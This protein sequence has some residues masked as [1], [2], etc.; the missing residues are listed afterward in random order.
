MSIYHFEHDF[1]RA[2]DHIRRNLDAGPDFEPAYLDLGRA[3]VQKRMFPQALANLTTAIELFPDSNAMLMTRGYANGADGRKAQANA[4]LNRSR[5]SAP[6]CSSLLLLRDLQ[7]AGRP[8]ATTC[9]AWQSTPGA[10]IT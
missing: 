5:E 2:I 8:R 4:I 1:E 7:G 10:A 3:Y 9:V 6:L